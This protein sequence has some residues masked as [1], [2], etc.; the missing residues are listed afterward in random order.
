[1]SEHDFVS[2]DEAID[3]AS[4]DCTFVGANC[5]DVRNE[6][7][8]RRERAREW[9]RSLDPATPMVPKA[10]L[11]N[12]CK[13][14]STSWDCPWLHSDGEIPCFKDAPADGPGSCL[15]RDEDIAECWL[16][17]LARPAAA[18]EA[19]SDE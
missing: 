8:S 7:F 3:A 19:G 4:R 11:R 17:H 15:M 13:M 5:E 2:V 12:A 16:L 10:A 18:Q 6:C 1:M 14:L 9:L